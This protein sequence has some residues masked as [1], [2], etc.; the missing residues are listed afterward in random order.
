M[1]QTCK[2]CNQPDKWDW[3]V[4]DTVWQRVLTGRPELA[5]RVVCLSCFDALAAQ[6]NVRFD[7]RDPVYFVGDAMTLHLKL[8]RGRRSD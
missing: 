5:E 4:P 2:V 6:E 3:H 1:R 7:L 8:T